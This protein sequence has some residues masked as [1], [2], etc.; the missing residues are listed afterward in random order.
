MRQYG[1]PDIFIRTFKALYHQSSSCVTEC[2][3]FSSWFEVKSGVRQG[4]PMS[5]FIFV[6]IMDWV[7]RHINNRR[8]GLRWKLTTVLEDLDYADDVA[9]I[10]SRFADLQEKIDRL[11][12][13]AGIV[14]LKIN[15]CKTKTLRIN[16][17]C[18]DYIRI[19]GEK[20]EDV[21]SF[22]YLGS[23]LDKLG[24]TE[25]D[26]K[27]RL[28]LARIAFTSLQNIWRSGRFSQKTKLR[29][30]N[31]NVLSVLLY[32]AEMWRVT[33]TDLNKVDVFHHTCLRR[34]LRRFWPYHLSNE[35]LYEATGSTPVSTLIRVRRW[36]W[37]G[38]ILRT[39]PNNISRTALAWAPEGKRRRGRP[40][41]TWRG[42]AKKERNQLGWHSRACCRIGGRPGWMAQSSGWPQES[43]WAR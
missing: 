22:V 19:E 30:L 10:S 42:T 16:H 8:R 15:P 5:G 40:R 24:G 38:H 12:A 31:S 43:S 14:G 23:V 1:I 21:K 28:A 20:V 29:I 17:R 2:R 27:R 41:E 3:R 25:A 4:C 9:L 35:E 39:S 11:V 26:I 18:T 13:T 33:T 6:L 34:V 36:R 7:M 37:I 32:G